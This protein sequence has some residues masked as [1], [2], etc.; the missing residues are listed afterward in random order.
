[1]RVREAIATTLVFGLALGGCQQTHESMPSEASIVIDSTTFEAP[2]ISADIV[3]SVVATYAVRTKPQPESSFGSGVVVRSPIGALALTAAHVIDSPDGVGTQV[4]KQGSVEYSI[5][6]RPGDGGIAAVTASADELQNI[7]DVGVM[8]VQ[9]LTGKF[10][11]VPPAHLSQAH[12][13]PKDGQIVDFVGWEPLRSGNING[14]GSL[15]NPSIIR[16]GESLHYTPTSIQYTPAESQGVVVG[17]TASGEWAVLTG[18]GTQN[19]YPGDSGGAVI[20]GDTVDGI[21]SSGQGIFIPQTV[22][23]IESD[24]R[25]K[26]LGADPSASAFI[27]NVEAVDQSD[28]NAMAYQLS[29]CR[30]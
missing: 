24:Y 21:V 16:L 13:S 12:L 28:V 5:Q 22:G 6:G 2:H 30:P 18:I 25:V 29:A 3:D 26:L 20:S 15:R 1:M 4:C 14:I 10:N 27:T 11:K 7:R 19:V 23:D 17:T 8:R 9:D